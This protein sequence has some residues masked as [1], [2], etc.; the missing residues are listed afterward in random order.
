MKPLFLLSVILAAGVVVAADYAPEL[1]T[2]TARATPAIVRVTPNMEAIPR[3]GKFEL[4]IELAASYDNPF[5]PEQV[6]LTAEFTTPSRKTIAVSGFFYQPYRTRNAGDDAKRP[7]LDAAGTPCWKVRFTPLET[8]RHTYVVR[9]RNNFGDARGDVTSATG[10][11]VAVAADAPGFIRVSPTNSRYFEFDDGRP[12]FAV[13]QNLQNDWPYYRHSRLLAEGGANCA[14]VWT[15]CHWT[16]LEWTFRSGLKWAGPGDWMRSYA[17]AGRYNQRIA[18]IADDCLERW[19]RDGLFVMLCLGNGT[20]GGELTRDKEASYGSWGGHPYNAANGGFLDEPQQFWTDERARRLYRQRLRYIIARWGYSPNV[21]AWEFW[22][23]LGGAAP[24]MVAWHEEMARYVR[25]RDPNRH[26][27]TTSTWEGNADKFAAMWDLQEMDFTQGHHYGPL[28]S[29]APR[30]AEHLRRW[31]KP[32]INGEGGGPS[33]QGWD[34]ESPGK[35]P[36][37]VD[38]DSVEFHNSLW[39]PAM[40]GSAG[41]TL[42]W[43]WRD[44]I[45]PKNLFFHYRAV[46]AFVRDVPWT[47]SRLR[48]LQVK[49]VKLV[50]DGPRRKYSPVLV[51]PFGADWGSKPEQSRFRVEADGAVSGLAQLRG[52]LFGKAPSRSQWRSPLTFATNFPESGRFIVHVSKVSHGVLEIRLDG[53]VAATGKNAGQDLSIDVP[54]GRHEVTFDNVGSDIVRFGYVLVTNYRDA[55]RHPDLDILGQQTDDFAAL[56]IHNRLHQWPYK[57]SGFDAEPVGPATAVI[58]GLK[59]GRYQ[60]QWWDT[61]K[62]GISKVEQAEVRSGT[63]DLRIPAVERDMACKIRLTNE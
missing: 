1:P 29:M 28:P 16:W 56:W 26:L 22:N 15:F 11:F 60:I 43:W 54:A 49:A 35:Q 19:T 44:R 46:A 9:L 58:A 40:S 30:I 6:D 2:M 37:S 55:A 12:F 63:L 4:T 32:Y 59:D 39:A 41:T 47:S 27:I 50:G 3:Y 57:A 53:A 23:E 17:G 14:R 20:G 36:L 52:E 25:Q 51:A 38:P 8:G 5:D 13:G 34:G 21:W 62:G 10:S 31:A 33:A 45:E 42:P 24:E 18:W 7:L 61:D 48:S